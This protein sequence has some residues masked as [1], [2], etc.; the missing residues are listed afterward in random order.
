MIDR[1]AELEHRYEEVGRRLST[2][3]VANDPSQ[4]ADLGREYS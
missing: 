4:L 2:P 3:D 1:L